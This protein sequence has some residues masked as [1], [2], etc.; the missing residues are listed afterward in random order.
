MLVTMAILAFKIITNLLIYAVFVTEATHFCCTVFCDIHIEVIWI[1][2]SYLSLF[3]PF[4]SD[5]FMY[6]QKYLFLEK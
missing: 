6:C 4:E 1:T 5:H 3:L 2:V